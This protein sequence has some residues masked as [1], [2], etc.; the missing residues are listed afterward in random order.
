[1][2]ENYEE[3]VDMSEEENLP[4]IFLENFGKNPWVE[5]GVGF[6]FHLFRRK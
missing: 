1:L 3:V 4:E 2:D 6:S 5:K